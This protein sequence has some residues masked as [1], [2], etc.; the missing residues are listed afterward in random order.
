MIRATVVLPVP[1]LPVKTMWYEIGA[2]FSPASMRCFATRTN[3]AKRATSSFTGVR[4]ISSL[5]S[6]RASS[7]VTAFV[8]AGTYFMPGG[9]VLSQ[10]GMSLVDAALTPFVGLP[11]DGGT[12]FFATFSPMACGV[13]GSLSP[14]PSSTLIGQKMAR[15]AQPMITTGTNMSH[16]AHLAVAGILSRKYP[17]IRA[18]IAS[19]IM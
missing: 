14:F 1:G 13:T 18:G 6:A 4:P 15:S 3:F 12:I 2:T 16:V 9:G 8:L 10:C 5:S 19:M 11:E 7:T 17:A